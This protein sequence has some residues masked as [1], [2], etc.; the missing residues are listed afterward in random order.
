M[1]YLQIDNPADYQAAL[2]IRLS[3]ED[4]T[5]LESQ[6]VTNQRDL[7]TAFARQSG[8]AVHDVYVDDGWSGT[9]F[10]R[11]GFQR[12]LGDI[13]RKKVNMV[14]TKDMSRLGRDYILTGHYLERYFPEHGVRYLSLLDGVDTGVDNSANDITP[15]RAIMNDWYAKDIS[16]KIKSVKHDKQRRG[17]FV[18]GKAVYGYRLS[19]QEKNKLVIDDEAAAVVRRIFLK[20]LQGQSCRQIAQRLNREGVPPPA[21]YAGLT[22]RAYSGL[23]SAERIADML[24][25]PTYI[26]HMVQG[27]SRR[28][29]Y[30]TAKSVRISPKNW[31]VVQDTHVPII[32]SDVFRRV[33]LLVASR[34][35]TRS[36]TYDYLLKGTICC[37]ECGRPLSVV[38]RPNAKGE[39]VLYFICRTY[40]RQPKARACTCHSA[41]VDTVTNAV[42]QRV[43]DVCRSYLDAGMLDE[44]AATLA[45]DSRRGGELQ[46]TLHALDAELN[47][48]REKLDAMY[49]D[50]LSGLLEEEDFVR[51][52]A[53]LRGRRAA[54]MQKRAALQAQR[55]RAPADLRSQLEELAQRF[56]REKDGNRTLLVSLIK[57]VELTQDK[58]VLLYFC[59]APPKAL[60][61]G[62]PGAEEQTAAE[63]AS[64]DA[65]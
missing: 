37:H 30:K 29:N 51:V 60:C 28:L 40:Q 11:P 32:E 13:E 57:R 15:F 44:M 53:H 25:N 46:A 12:M 42:L 27:K 61:A 2:Y 10:E 14:I 52:Y 9:S 50:K 55:Q 33:G 65:L 43:D 4:D 58:R 63:Q 64:E 5:E 26:G 18:G 20:A 56:L 54:L 41:R 19:S 35:S 6:S 21:V 36:R 45:K 24:Q 49:L 31:I 16:K 59:C 34:R 47:A 23:W 1:A 17:L 48:L 8:L 39:D 38:N 3:K 7:L 22:R 62:Q